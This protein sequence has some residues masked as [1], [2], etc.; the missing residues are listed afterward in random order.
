M[1]NLD[2]SVGIRTLGTAGEKYKT[3]IQAIKNQTVKPKE[4]IVVID[5][6]SKIDSLYQCG[7]ER[8]VVRPRGMVRQRIDCIKEN[9]SD[10]LL[11][12]DDDVSFG[13]NF[14]EKM[15]ETSLLTQTFVV[16][17]VVKDVDSA[18]GNSIKKKS[19]HSLMGG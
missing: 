5:D 17:P 14:V 19:I 11:L 3:T 1:I 10:W 7:L 12:L 6:K 13:E 18:L 9:S 4:I 8:F 16:E 15:F 2:Y